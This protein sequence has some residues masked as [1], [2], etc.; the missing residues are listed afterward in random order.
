[1]EDKIMSA[2]RHRR[3]EGVTK[4]GGIKR[5]A[6]IRE[7][8]KKKKRM[9]NKQPGAM[10]GAIGAR[11]K[12]QARAMRG[13]TKDLGNWEEKTWTPSREQLFRQKHHDLSKRKRGRFS[14]RVNK[15]HRK[16]K[17]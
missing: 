14:N 1:M 6:K 7:K 8:K 9:R 3:G 17:K 2:G 10:L 15:R 12:S 16:G 4:C 5:Q 13:V 11:E